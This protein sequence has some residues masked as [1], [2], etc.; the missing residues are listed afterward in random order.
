MLSSVSLIIDCFKQLARISIIDEKSD[1][2]LNKELLLVFAGVIKIKKKT[3]QPNGKPRYFRS[4]SISIEVIRAQTDFH[5]S[6][7]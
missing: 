5:G 7:I 6:T 2:A 4:F 3:S 1:Q